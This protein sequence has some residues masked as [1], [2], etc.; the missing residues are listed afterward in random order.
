MDPEGMLIE[1]FDEIASLAAIY[2]YPYYPAHMVKLGF[3][4]A[5]DW[6]QFDI[7][8]PPEVPEKIVRSAKI[9]REKYHLHCLHTRKSK[10]FLPYTKKMFRMLNEAFDELYGF[11]ALSDEQIDLFIKQYFGFIRPEFV[12]LVLDEKEDVIAFG[13]TI[14]DLANALQKANG[15]L[16]PFGFYHLLRALRK[17]DT[18]HMY[19]IGVRPDYQGKGALALIYEQLNEAYVRNG[20]I[21]AT[22]HAQLE[23]NH[24]AISIWKNYEGRIYCRRRCW[25]RRS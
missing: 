12:S 3:I 19:L 22:T 8:V 23:D 24:K 16:F 7:A 4:K 6:L 20:I 5:A 21:R 13:V 9:V 2:N 17:N 25:I 1:G 11:A 18:I 10:D 14:P 15:R